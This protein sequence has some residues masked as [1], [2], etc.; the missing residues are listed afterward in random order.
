MQ[1]YKDIKYKI[2]V[3][4]IETNSLH[5][6]EASLSLV[7]LHPGCW[8]GPIL[9]GV[10]RDPGSFCFVAPLSSRLVSTPSTVEVAWLP[11][12]QSSYGQEGEGRQVSACAPGP[13]QSPHGAERGLMDVISTWVAM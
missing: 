10:T 13:Q 4:D 8:G 1:I 11:H 7:G 2:W 6:T 5:E 12:L 9:H 3:K